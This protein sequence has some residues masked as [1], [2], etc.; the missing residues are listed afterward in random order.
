VAS[1]RQVTL[2]WDEAA[3]TVVDF[4]TGYNDFEGYRI[5]RTSI[6]PGRDKW[7]K[8]MYDGDGKLVGFVPIAQFDLINK[9]QGLDP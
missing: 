1:D 8:E 7:G 2:Y 5:Y 3:E 4:L 9:I 6:D